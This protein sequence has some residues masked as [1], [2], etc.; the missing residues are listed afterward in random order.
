MRNI[1]IRYGTD[2]IL[3]PPP[4]L[5]WADPRRFVYGQSEDDFVGTRGAIAFIFVYSMAYAVILNVMIWVLSFEIFPFFLRSKGVAMA[6][7][8]KAVVA[9]VLS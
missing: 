6:V 9:I 8:I 5:S 4:G 1:A 2:E 7:F 3:F